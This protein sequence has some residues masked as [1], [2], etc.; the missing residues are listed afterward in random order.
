MRSLLTGGTGYLGGHLIP[1]LTREG[2][3]VTVTVR[4]NSGKPAPS[5]PDGVQVLTIPSGGADLAQMISQLAPE[6]LIHCATRPQLEHQSEDLL[7]LI[8]SN[9]TFALQV[10]DA[11]VR[12]GCSRILN[13]S[14]FWQLDA[15]GKVQP[16]SLYAGLK[17]SVED[18][19]DFYV[20]RF[21]TT[22]ISLRL[23]DVLGPHDARPKLVN[24]ILKLQISDSL[25]LSSGM[26]KIVPTA[27]EDVVE[28]LQMALSY[29]VIKGEHRRFSVHGTPLKLRDFVE[30][31][32]RLRNVKGQLHWSGRPESALQIYDPFLGERL[33]GWNP[34]V[35]L[36]K[37]IQS[38]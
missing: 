33:P 3:Q 18:C 14:T 29:H 23:Y 7:P 5:F 34:R 11:S 12:A 16:N 31:L 32:V 17:Q 26:Q 2:H 20:R 38:L 15:T 4:A 6:A 1:R 19:L 8:E 22:A 30:T 10:I 25:A 36:E 13:C 37:L 27:I 24:Q 9:F 28:A 21:Q 35:S